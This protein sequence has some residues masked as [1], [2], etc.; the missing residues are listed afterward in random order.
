VACWEVEVF[1]GHTVDYRVEFDDGGVD[2]VA[3]EGFGRGA[4]SEADDQGLCFGVVDL[5]LGFHQA[6][7]FEHVEGCVDGFG[8]L[9][10][11]GAA[12]FGELPFAT[13]KTVVAAHDAVVGFGVLEDADVAGVAPLAIEESPVLGVE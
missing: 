10:A 1:G 8:H 9:P 7:G 12:L 11:L 5:W 6:D 2:A 13:E 4:D 3:D